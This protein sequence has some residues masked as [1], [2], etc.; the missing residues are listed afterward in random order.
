MFGA[1]DALHCFCVANYLNIRTF[2]ESLEQ[3]VGFNTEDFL[4][5]FVNGKR[6]VDDIDGAAAQSC[7][8]IHCLMQLLEKLQTRNSSGSRLRNFLVPS[9]V[10]DLR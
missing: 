7:K 6:F 4:T 10:L 2:C 9:R 3:R 1:I 5:T 8:T